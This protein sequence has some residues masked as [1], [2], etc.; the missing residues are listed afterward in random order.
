VPQEDKGL[1]RSTAPNPNGLLT[2]HA[3]DNEQCHVWCI[4]GLS[5]VPIDS[6]GWNS[7]WGYKYPQP[8]PFKLSKFS[9]LH[10]QYTIKRSNPLQASKSTQLLSDLREGVLCFFCCSC[11]LDCFFPSHSKLLKCFVKLARDT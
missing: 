8:P 10:I 7:G 1:Q 5:G 4:T 9:A 11:Y 6:N 2:W 3:P